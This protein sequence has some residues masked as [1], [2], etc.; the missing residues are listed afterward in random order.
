VKA[1]GSPSCARCFTHCQRRQADSGTR[2]NL[3]QVVFATR[4]LCADH[5]I[6]IGGLERYASRWVWPARRPEWPGYL[7]RR[8]RGCSASLPDPCNAVSISLASHG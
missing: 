2:R 3:L 7:F 4:V 5:R 1:L 6:C 8:Q